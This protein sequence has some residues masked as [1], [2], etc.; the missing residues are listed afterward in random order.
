MN[1]TILHRQSMFKGRAF[2]VEQVQLR[3][4]DE[5]TTTY[6]LVQHNDSI[7]LVPFDQDGKVWFVRQYRLGAQQMLLELP[8]GVLD[9]H[10]APETGAHREIRE[11]IGQ[12]AGQLTLLGD[13]Y[14]AP[15]YASEHMFVFLATALSP[16]P[17]EA[18]DDEFL[19]LESIPAEKALAMARAGQF[20]DAKTVASLLLAEKYILGKN[21]VS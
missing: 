7:T 21:N 13:F 15:G 19:E 9:N 18:D 2:D 3:L 1:F 12:A 4:P 8:A 17:L 6:D 20:K 5:R 16:A 11:E 10:E 14:L